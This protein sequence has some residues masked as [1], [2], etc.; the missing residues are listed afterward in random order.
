MADYF[1]PTENLPSFNSSVFYT[2]TGA[3][4]SQAQAD[5]LYLG[6]TGTPNSVAS[7]TSFAGSITIP[8]INTTTTVVAIGNNAGATT[9]GTNGVAVGLNAGQ[10]NQGVS[11]VAIGNSS[12]QTN[13]GL[14][15]H[16]VIQ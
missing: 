15:R 10:T 8:R 16:F 3:G 6:R 2:D 13:Q 12:G 4:I 5:L 1:P 9:Q 11:A 14:W 7:A